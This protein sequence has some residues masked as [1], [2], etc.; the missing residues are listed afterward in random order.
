MPRRSL[1]IS[2]K[3]STTSSTLDPATSGK[4]P[5]GSVAA[6]SSQPTGN[7]K[8][9]RKRSRAERLPTKRRKTT[10]DDLEEDPSHEQGK[11]ALLEDIPL[12]IVFEIFSYLDS[13][14]LHTLSRSTRDFRDI[15]KDKS[16]EFA[17]RRAHA[18]WDKPPPTVPEGMDEFS[19]AELLFGV[20]CYICG[21]QGKGKDGCESP[22]WTFQMRCCRA[23]A[24]STFPLFHVLKRKQ[25]EQYR[26]EDILPREVL[27]RQY[28]L[29]GTIPRCQ[30]GN[31]A[32]TERLKE[33][34]DALKTEDRVPW[35]I[36]MRQRRKTIFEYAGK[37]ND[38]YLTMSRIRRQRML[39]R[40]STAIVK[41]L[42]EL[43]LQ[44]EIDKMNRHSL[45]DLVQFKSVDHTKVLTDQEWQSLEPELVRY[46]SEYKSRRLKLEKEALVTQRCFNLGKALDQILANADH[47]NPLPGH[48]DIL[49]DPSFQDLVID[50]PAEDG[51]LTEDFFKSR[52]AEFLP[53]FL[54]HWVP[55]KVQEM[56]A[57]LQKAIPTATVS[58]LHLA[59]STF[60]CTSCCQP[61]VFPEMFHHRCCFR[62]SCQKPQAR[63]A[64]Y[65]ERLSLSP[66][67]CCV[68]YSPTGSEFIYMQRIPLWNAFVFFIIAEDT[69]GSSCAGQELFGIVKTR[70]SLTVIAKGDLWSMRLVKIHK[71]S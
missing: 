14:D 68:E 8:A 30:L 47:R 42:K 46:I 66:W 52:L 69:D 62:W 23:C 31:T 32:M 40:R 56:L 38:W 59:A 43:G 21:R 19:Y 16:A 65:T 28:T 57:V 36:A 61:M 10:L 17:W 4:P 50:T 39:E 18:N 25:P 3:A 20:H 1:R 27:E 26:D 49:N 11:R 54:E 22:L 63:L 51:T 5:A 35:I 12:D 24:H 44:E 6:N 48:G 55:N 70:I 2:E 45:Q 13:G 58:D 7:K 33:E 9:S 34:F 60:T 71:L 53:K 67:I 29:E 41:N 37:C 64:F 15:L